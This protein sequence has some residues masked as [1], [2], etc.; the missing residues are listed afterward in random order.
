MIPR[1][2]LGLVVGLLLAGCDDSKTS[3]SDPGA[4]KPDARLAGV[5]QFRGEDGQVTYY[6]MGRADEKLPES[7]MRVVGVTHGEGKVEPPSEL[8][9]F[10]TTLD[11]KTYL[12]VTEG[13]E[14]QVKLIEEKGWKGVE[15]YF[16]FKYQIDGDKLLVWVMDGDA[17]KRAIEGGQIK[18]VAEK[19]KPAK[20]TDTTEN[21]A[22]FVSQAGGSLFPNDPIKLARVEGGSPKP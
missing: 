11:G 4:S 5:W 12:N 1:T 22:R 15:S 17:K 3:L 10:P 13:K 21:L 8:L 20:F 9:I 18:G 16:I 19:N 7:V 14:R 6:H 2:F